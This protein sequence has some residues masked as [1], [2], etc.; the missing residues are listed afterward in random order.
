MIYDLCIIYAWYILVAGHV[1]NLMEVP[2]H[3]GRSTA[4]RSKERWPS[5]A[6]HGRTSSGSPSCP[7]CSRETGNLR[8][9]GRLADPQIPLAWSLASEKGN[10][11]YRKY[12]SHAEV[13]LYTLVCSRLYLSVHAIFVSAPEQPHIHPLLIQY[14]MHHQSCTIRKSWQYFL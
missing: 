11:S 6:R 12:A 5:S 10:M 14:F 2:I 7:S 3:Q 1:T 13:D 4:W 9:S 8:Q